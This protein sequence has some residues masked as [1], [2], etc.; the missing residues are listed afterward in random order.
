[1]FNN[2]TNIILWSFT[3]DQLQS[4]SDNGRDKIYFEF[5]NDLI[6]TTE[7]QLTIHIEVQC[8][9]LRI[10]IHVINA[11]LTVKL[12]GQRDNKEYLSSD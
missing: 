1:M 7:N 3:F 4:S 12:I 9:H 10:L 8:Q 11:F 2:E 6:S 5:K